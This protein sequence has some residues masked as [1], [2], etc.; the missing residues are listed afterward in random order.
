MDNAEIEKMDKALA[1][2]FIKNSKKKQ[3]LKRDDLKLFRGRCIDLIIIFV[4]LTKFN[5]SE[6]AI[7]IFFNKFK[8]KR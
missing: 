5:S 8:K 2:A 1:D 3:K 7:V 4:S 6:E